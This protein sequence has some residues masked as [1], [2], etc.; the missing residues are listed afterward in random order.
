MSKDTADITAVAYVGSSDTRADAD[1]VAGRTNVLAGAIADGNIAVAGR[2]VTKRIKTDGVV[3]N[4]G[5]VGTERI[6]TDGIV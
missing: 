2:I 1:N 4:P 3:E 6:K 5:C